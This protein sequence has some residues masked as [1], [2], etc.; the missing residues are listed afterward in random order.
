MRILI[1]NWRDIK[2]PHAGGAEQLTHE[3]AKRWVQKGHIVTQFSAG[4]TGCVYDEV[5][6]GVR[7][8]RRGSWW[9][10][11]LFA[12][13]YYIFELRSAVD[14]IIDEVHWFPYFAVVYARDK[15]VLLACEVAN[16]RF[17]T[18]FPYPVAVMWRG[19]EKLYLFLYRGVPVMAISPSTKSELVSEGFSEKNIIVLPM[20]VTI[21]SSVVVQPKEKKP[22]ILFLG[23]INVLK[24][25]FDALEVFKMVKRSVPDAIMWFAGSGEKDVITELHQRIQSY[26]L[27][28]CVQFFGFVS[29]QEKFALLSRARVLL[30][31]SVH[32]GWGLIVSEAA[33]VG[34]PSV[35]YDVPGL[36]D[37]LTQGKTGCI[38]PPEP[39]AM[40]EKVTELLTDTSLYARMR[41]AIRHHRISVSWDTTADQALGFMKQTVD[42]RGRLNEAYGES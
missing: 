30:V 11:S 4:Y 1:G 40:A 27:S 34:T 41:D 7:I 31:P 5:V 35:V 18:L 20:G 36:R 24:G 13:L 23:R 14:V 9:N 6:D 33:Y 42:T 2:N 32:E 39:E 12:C 8:L 10:V 38:T 22:V 29:E 25:A 17:F 3:M 26:G 15:T 37:T 19:L 16:K 21:P 28:D